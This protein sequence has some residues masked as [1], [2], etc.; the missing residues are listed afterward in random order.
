MSQASSSPKAK[1]DW[2]STMAIAAL[3]VSLTVAFHEGIHAL[4]CII[5]GSDLQEY[6]ALHVDCASSTITQSKIVAGSASLANLVLG[7]ICLI[8]LR[9]SS[10]QNSAWQ[11]FLW[12][13]ML[14]N[15]LNGTGYWMFSGI[16][17][18]GDW[19]KV[20]EGWTPHW[21]WRVLMTIL[22][23][24]TFMGCVWVALRVLGTIIGGSKDEQIRRAVKLGAL[25][26]IASILVILGAGLLHPYGPT[27]LPVIAGLI[28][29][30][31]SQ[32]PLLWMMQWFRAKSFIKL[33]GPSLEIH[34]SW[35]WVMSSVIVT[36]IYIFIL[37]RTIYF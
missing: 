36:S 22:G 6:G 26:Y 29:V 8:I 24:G 14:M 4:S 35:S 5:V 20:I 19:A 25:S 31:G 27:S 33:S 13:F 28:A 15:W 32:S 16:A 23:T 11:F 17:N 2:L 12:L 18:I 21:V 10:Q 30:C 3:S 1:V 9:R 34:R 37:G 7:T